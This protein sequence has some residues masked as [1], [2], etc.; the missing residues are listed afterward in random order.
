MN[1]R[2]M[3]AVLT[4]LTLSYGCVHEPADTPVPTVLPPTT[5]P[6][7]GLPCDPDSVYFGNSIQPLLTSRCAIP[8]CH[9]AVTMQD[10]VNLSS[11]AGVMSSGVINVSNPWNSDLLERITDNDPDDRMPPPPNAPLTQQ[12]IDMLYAWMAQGAKN[13]ACQGACDTTVFT[14]SGAVRP[15]TQTR[16]QG[17]HSGSTPQGGILLTDYNNIRTVALNGRLYGAVSHA[18]GFTPMP[19][20]SPKI[21]DCEITQI[22]KWIADGTPNN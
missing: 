17:C 4:A 5:P 7:T 10:G 18:A 12:Q 14:F 22:R 11:Y 20:N 8:G 2:P 13:N 15:I 6:V 21:P 1:L 3:M 9:D 19:Y 16:C